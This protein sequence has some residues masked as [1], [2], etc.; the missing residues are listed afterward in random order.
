MRWSVPSTLVLRTCL[1]FWVGIGMDVSILPL[2]EEIEISPDPCGLIELS[3]AIT[4][5]GLRSRKH[6]VN[7]AS[8][9]WDIPCDTC[10]L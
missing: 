7:G 9:R 10:G 4:G 2:T 5:V 1:V 3:F 6:N 8:R